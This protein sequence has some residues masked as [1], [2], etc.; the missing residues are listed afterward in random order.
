MIRLE[1][2]FTAVFPWLSSSTHTEMNDDSLATLLPELIPLDVAAENSDWHK[3]TA[4]AQSLRLCEWVEQLPSSLQKTAD[5]PLNIVQTWLK[6]QV[7]KERTVHQL[8]T[9]VALLHDIGKAQT[10][11]VQPDGTT[12]CPQHEV[13]GAEIAVEVCKRFDFTC[14]EHTFVET[15]VREHGSPYT[16]YK[17]FKTLPRWKAKEQEQLFAKRHCD[18]LR[19]LLLLAYGDLVTSDLPD[20]H[21]AKYE[22]I[23]TFYKGWLQ[24]LVQEDMA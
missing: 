1:T 11:Q 12:R 7:T 24:M 4:L 13:V 23:A 21:L 8:L 17:N 19:P 6:Q 20:N 3:D 16:C 2:K 18:Y 10:I 9:F 15:L 5:L 22:G 14:V